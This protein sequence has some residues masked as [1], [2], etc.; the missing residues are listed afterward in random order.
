[1]LKEL[2]QIIHDLRNQ[3]INAESDSLNY[4]KQVKNE[5]IKRRFATIANRIERAIKKTNGESK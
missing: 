2:K 4:K 3:V 5:L 1:M